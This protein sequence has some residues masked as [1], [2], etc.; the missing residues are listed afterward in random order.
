MK[1]IESTNALGRP[2]FLGQYTVFK[3]PHSAEEKLLVDKADMDKY[4]H[5]VWIAVTR[6]G[7]ENA[8]LWAYNHVAWR[9]IPDPYV[10]TSV[11]KNLAANL[12]ARKAESLS[13][14]DLTTEAIREI[15][16]S[17]M[18]SLAVTHSGIKMMRFAVESQIEAPVYRLTEIEHALAVATRKSALLPSSKTPCPD[19]LE[20]AIKALKALRA[21][22][23][24]SGGLIPIDD[25]INAICEQI[26]DLKRCFDHP[27]DA[28]AP[29]PVDGPQL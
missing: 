20:T 11:L 8:A 4:G 5:L 22:R 23:D 1:P 16:D 29:Q 14:E 6:N 7:V 27:Q 28:I 18:L 15:A 13:D 2:S 9:G 26:P 17:V 21:G 10:R 12:A 25:Q 3:S 19:E 24:T